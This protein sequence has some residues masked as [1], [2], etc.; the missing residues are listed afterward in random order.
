LNRNL[1]DLHGQFSQAVQQGLACIREEELIFRQCYKEYLTEEGEFGW[2]GLLSDLLLG[3]V[4]NDLMLRFLWLLLDL[5]GKFT[6]IEA[7]D[8]AALGEFYQH[9]VLIRCEDDHYMVALP[10]VTFVEVPITS[11]K[12]Q[13]LDG[14]W[15]ISLPGQP[16]RPE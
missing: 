13:G 3:K 15:W 2:D 9:G 16:A 11:V 1:R 6:P 14:Q 4:Q 7:T 10:Q 12:C 5:P 8:A